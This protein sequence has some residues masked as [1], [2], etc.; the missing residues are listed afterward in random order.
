MSCTNF[1]LPLLQSHRSSYACHFPN[2][3]S[4]KSV[5]YHNCGEGKYKNNSRVDIIENLHLILEK[6]VYMRKNRDKI[7][8]CFQFPSK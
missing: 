2:S 5:E 6:R 4:G 1:N 8:D 3:K 7:C